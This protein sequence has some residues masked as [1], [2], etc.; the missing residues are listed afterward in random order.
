MDSHVWNQTDHENGIYPNNYKYSDIRKWLNNDFLQQAFYYDSSLIQT[1]N[2]DNSVE[3]TGDSSNPYACE[4]TQD[5][6]YLLSCKDIRN[7][8]YGFTD[9]ASRI[10]Y[11]ADGNARDHWLRS[12]NYYVDNARCV[13]SDGGVVSNLIYYVSSSYGV[14]PALTRKLD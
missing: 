8:D 2:V 9:D 12:P 10:A 14:R 13:S 6:V 7:K 11:D 4:D 1:V 3:S 5:K